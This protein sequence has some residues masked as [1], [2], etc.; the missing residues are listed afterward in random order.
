MLVYANFQGEP[1][2]QADWFHLL[3][4][5]TYGHVASDSFMGV[6]VDTSWLGVSR[7][8]DSKA[9]W[10]ITRAWVNKDDTPKSK[11]LKELAKTP[12]VR[13]SATVRDARRLHQE[14]LADVKI[15]GKKT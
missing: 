7:D 6:V 9:L 4:N 13:F 8:N 10:F 5:P 2:T 14:V 1:I 11:G 15:L 12:I 3:C